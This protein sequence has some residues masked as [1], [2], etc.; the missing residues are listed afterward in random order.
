MKWLLGIL[1]VCGVAL[2][3]AWFVT[4]ARSVPTPVRAA[5]V[6]WPGATVTPLA[7]TSTPAPTWTRVPGGVQRATVIC[8]PRPTRT[9]T[10]PPWLP[11]QAPARP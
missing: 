7:P 2:S 5:T 9:P 6:R 4:S 3:P 11:T 1:L 8:T 10:E